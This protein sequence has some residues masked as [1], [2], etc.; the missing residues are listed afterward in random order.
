MSL[1]PLILKL[2]L[3][4]YFLIT[5]TY[6]LTQNKLYFGTGTAFAFLGNSLELESSAEY[7]RPVKMSFDMGLAYNVQF[8]EGKF[9][10]IQL[11][12]TPMHLKD[13]YIF[14]DSRNAS[15]MRRNTYDIQLDFMRTA[16]LYGHKYGSFS[17]AAGLEYGRLLKGKESYLQVLIIDN[18]EETEQFL[19]DEEIDFINKNNWGLRFSLGYE[20]S[21]KFKLSGDLMLGLS[22]LL[23][24]Q[25]QVT[26]SNVNWQ[27]RLSCLSFN[28]GYML[29]EE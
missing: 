27:R 4:F 8:K 15:L 12:Y 3:L 21:S 22:N 29:H 28:L 13:K 7:S 6:C 16:L 11:N 17:I 23:M 26:V 2:S 18:V 5:H 9:V 20:L 14:T 1:M 24:D 25:S 19:E 10:N